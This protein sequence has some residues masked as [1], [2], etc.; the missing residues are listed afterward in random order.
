MLQSNILSVKDFILN[1]KDFEKQIEVNNK[2]IAEKNILIE[3][4]NN[5]NDIFKNEIKNVQDKRNDLENKL[6]EIKKEYDEF[7]NLQHNNNLELI[8]S[9]NKKLYEYKAVK[10]IF[11]NTY[12]N[13]SLLG[14]IKYRIFKNN[15]EI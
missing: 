8:A 13:R 12:E 5:K 15:R 2:V 11:Q 4:L 9:L 7:K 14:V 10:K 6:K 3:D 1:K